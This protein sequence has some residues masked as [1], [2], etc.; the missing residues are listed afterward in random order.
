MTEMHELDIP[1]A[2][3]N[4]RM[5]WVSDIAAEM[6]RRLGI[7]YIALNPGASYRGLHDSLVNY[8]GNRD[9]QMLLCLHEDHPVAIAHGYAKVTGEP[10]AAVV[11]SNVGLLHGLMAV[12]NA[13]CDRM[14]VYLLGA[15]G[16][17][18]AARRRPWIDWI[19]TAKDQGALLRNF[20]KW[21][22]EPRSPEALV[23]SMLRGA[24]MARTPP[25]GPVYLCLDA[26]MQETELDE[27]MEIPDVARFAP[28]EPQAASAQAIER[29][30]DLL[31]EAKRP[32]VLMG[33]MSRDQADWD[34]RR[35]LA[36]LLGAGVLTDIKI[37]ATFPTDH[38]LHVGAPSLWLRGER[39]DALCQADAVLSL[40]WVDLAG[41]FKSAGLGTD[42]PAQVI[43]CSV[44]IHA[45]NG[46]S[47]DH[48]GLAPSDLTVHA[49]PDGFVAQLLA[50]LEARLDG[51]PR[52][53]N[54]TPAPQPAEPPEKA[55]DAPLEP[56]DIGR[57]LAAARGARRLTL[58]RVTLGW[59]ASVYHFREP[60]DFIGYDGGAGL[61]SATG[62]TIGAALALKGTGR[63]PV[64]V[65]GDGD[66]MQGATAL[67]TAARY[68]IP[69]LF[70]IANNRSNFNDEI[71]Q[72]ATARVRGRP[73]ENKWIG[74]R[75]DDP[76]IDIAAL[77]RAQGI[78]AE[79]PVECWGALSQAIEA[80]LVAVEA[81]R[82]HLIDVWVEPGYN[83]PLV[84]R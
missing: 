35:R 56:I 41:T 10:M 74:Q 81:G 63:L 64:A 61:G 31:L 11:H 71:H 34:N 47:M 32:L 38:P 14:P 5:G 36:E 3:D 9:P 70:V 39:A 7:R 13:W 1:E 21:D 50:V 78:E 76:P 45:H 83:T 19:H 33:R 24:L 80:G 54:G 12:F 68:R 15:T 37:A 55:P 23:E 29:A 59:D 43:S 66:F 73:V 51:K 57:A 60:L 84:T 65:I 22:D 27:P 16:P 77:A 26:G 67:W 79:G 48:F 6:L 46:W 30:A 69:A 49:D 18:D 8:L 2:G 42:V 28:G 58:T 52:W 25:Q 44:D 75:I 72:E 17:V 4:R 20:T 82:P 53:S 62:I 40:D